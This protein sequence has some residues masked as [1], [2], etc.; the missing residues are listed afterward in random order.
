M[1][2][3]LALRDSLTKS[4]AVPKDGE[5]EVKG[6]EAV[7]EEKKETLA[8]IIDSIDDAYLS[9]LKEADLDDEDISDIDESE[10]NLH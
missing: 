5:E 9:D 7:K 3:Y 4:K 2:K 6:T 8:E 1:I 10:I